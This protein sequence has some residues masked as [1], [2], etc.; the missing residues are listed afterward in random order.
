[1][2]SRSDA[3]IVGIGASA[4]GI[5]ALEAMFRAM[6]GQPGLAFVVVAHL[7][8]GRDTA[9]PA[10]IGRFTQMP[11]VLAHDGQAVEADHVYV[12]PPNATLAV[13]QHRLVVNTHEVPHAERNPI[14]SFLGS[15]ADDQGEFAIAVILSGSG[16]DGMLGIK[17][18]KERGGL[19]VAQGSGRCRPATPAC[20]PAPSAPAWSTW[21][22]RPRLSRPS[23]RSICAALRSWA[24]L[25]PMKDSA[26]ARAAIRRRYARRSAP[27]CASGSA[28]DFTGYKDQ[29]LHAARATPDAGAAG[30]VSGG[31]CRAAAA[32]PRRG[33]R[34]FSRP[35]DQR[36]QLLPRH[37]GLR[38][39]GERRHPAAVR[40]QGG[41]RHC[42]GLGPG[43]CNRRRGLLDR[44]PAARAHATA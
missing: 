28:H 29:H 24:A 34:C 23:W 10:I 31:L 27:S 21:C 6:P 19:T 39:L 16:S 32:G 7:A 18:I 41:R 1:M 13:R 25:R 3:P 15:L 9:L 38:R 33:R 22:C 44:D 4:G 40:G 30:H 20:R 26:A 17:A 8:P 11:A 35:A 2:A 14:D 12:A 43:L 37:R 36:H 42:S 5:E